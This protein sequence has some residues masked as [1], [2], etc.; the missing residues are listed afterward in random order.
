MP[1]KRILLMYISEISGHRS[2]A[3]A[4]EKAIKEL[5]PS[6]EIMGINAFGYTN[7]VSEKIINRFYMGV[8][9]N[10][11]QLWSYLYDNPF[12]ARKLEKI[13]KAVH[14]V[15]SVKLKALFDRFPADVVVCT[16]AFPCGMVADYKKS[17]GSNL[18]LFAVLTDYI[19]HSY[20][21]YDSVDCY[22]TPSDDV[23]QQLE[24][25]GVPGDKIK[26]LG[27]P[28]N[29]AFNKTV[30]REAVVRKLDLKENTPTV[31]I[32]GGGHGLGP[33]QK[34]VR[35]L[36]K[37]KKEIN[38]IIVSGANKKLYNSL[39]KAVKKCR[40]NTLL[41]E[42]VDNIP[43]LMSVSDIIITKPGGI[44]TAE[45]LTKKMPMLIIKPIPGQEASNA[46]YL[47]RKGAALR[48]ENIDEAHIIVEKLLD[49]PERLREI[50]KCAE[51]ISR[52][53]ASTDIARLIL[54][55]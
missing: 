7:P 51:K 38:E 42:Y 8:I 18:K 39:R 43:E 9:K 26:D 3:M 53:N 21:I 31:L 1:P 14:K 4:I 5:E 55:A 30:D 24:K 19:P 20:W 36:E 33:I 10:I 44:T 35:S 37:I 28:F 50:S 40:Q 32:M 6:A 34:I 16:Q 2:A 29:P 46:D 13:K 22:I 17:R 12:V 48:I 52:P 27:I 15:N 11:P 25:K 47:V 45:A 49:N 23:S 41:F 54:E